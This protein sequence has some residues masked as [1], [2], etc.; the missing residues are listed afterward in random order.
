MLLIREA[1]RRY[2]A[3][4]ILVLLGLLFAGIGDMNIGEMLAIVCWIAAAFLA[5][6]EDDEDTLD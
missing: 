2:Q 3:T 6:E 1:W 4:F 5:G